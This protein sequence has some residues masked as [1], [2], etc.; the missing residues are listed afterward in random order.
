MTFAGRF[1]TPGMAVWRIAIWTLLGGL[2]LMPAIAMQFTTEVVWDKTDF[3]T[4]ALLLGGGGAAFEA[5]VR[6]TTKPNTRVVIG[7]IIVLTVVVLW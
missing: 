7:A 2:L 5:V 6:M 4:A 1:G 3:A